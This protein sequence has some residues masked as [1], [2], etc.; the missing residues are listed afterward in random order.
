M[1]NMSENRPEIVE[2][3]IKYNY[4]MTN[5]LITTVLNRLTKQCK[6]II[7]MLSC[8]YFG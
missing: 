3:I 1:E 4:L 2:I 6:I 8:V 5:S 7:A